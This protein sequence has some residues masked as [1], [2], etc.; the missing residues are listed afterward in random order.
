VPP[1]FPLSSL[2]ASLFLKNPKPFYTPIIIKLVDLCITAFEKGSALGYGYA[3]ISQALP[4]PLALLLK[5]DFLGFKK[6]K[7]VYPAPQLPV[8]KYFPEL[9]V[10]L[11][12]PGGRHDVCR[13]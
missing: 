8:L 9:S 5:N 2:A 1:D 3:Q 12:S 13:P 11:G 10:V 7:A 6:V 4:T